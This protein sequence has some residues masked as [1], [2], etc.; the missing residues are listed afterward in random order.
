MP[1][2]FNEAM[3]T[4]SFEIKPFVYLFSAV[5][6][7]CFCFDTTEE[8]LKQPAYFFAFL[9]ALL[10]LS[11][12]IKRL[13]SVFRD[14]VCLILTLGILL[15]LL[16]VLYTAIWTRQHDV[17]DFGTGE[18]HAGYIEYLYFNNSLPDGD[19]RDRWAFFQPPLHHI[20]SAIWMK[21]CNRFRLSYRQLQENVQALTFFYVASSNV[22]SYFICRELKLKGR[23]LAAAMTIT[24]FHPVFVIMSGSI[25]N[26]ALSLFFMVLSLYLVI[27]WY[28]RPS[29]LLIILLAL[30]IGLSMMAKLSGGLI[31]PAVASLFLYRLIKDRKDTLKYLLQYA[32]F[33]V[34]V[35]PLGLW[36][37]V[38]NMLG[39]GMPLNY[40]PPVGEQLEKTGLFSRLFDLRLISVYPSMIKNG[41][42]F[43]E[44][45]VFWAML[46]TS[47]F[48]DENLSLEWRLIDPF[49]VVLFVSGLILL[50]I[51]LYATFRVLSERG[52]SSLAPEWK[53]LLGVFYVTMVAAYL[54]FA[55]GSPNYSAQSFRYI[56]ATVI[57]EAVFL[58]LFLG[59]GEDEGRPYG[60]VPI[61]TYVFALS[62][63]AVYVLLGF[64]R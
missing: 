50:I 21:L 30:S 46:K 41:D 5:L 40:I 28:K 52:E 60:W 61:L 9:A 27:L 24:A 26:D 20:I 35:F 19:P 62:S 18:G 63:A 55:L 51:C 42:P 4:D 47:L 1:V 53:L 44:Y 6:I 8:T 37:E 25:N 36:W 59:D 23:G 7:I 49:A 31:A 43:D 13:K 11:V 12:N 33:G 2:S 58:G 10:I 15:K 56:S 64:A 29:F 45:N 14:P 22:L 57:L 54:S 39:F 32:V 38:R 16:Y 3:K 17:V 48:D 34:I